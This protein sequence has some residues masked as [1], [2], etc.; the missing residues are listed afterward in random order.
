MPEAHRSGTRV[1][2]DISATLSFLNYPDLAPE[3]CR[4]LVVNAQECGIRFHR[5]LGL[6]TR[7]QFHGLRT[8]RNVIARVVN[9]IPLHP[10]QKAWFIQLTLDESGNVWG[11]EKPPDDWQ[12]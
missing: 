12:I 7:V 10:Y 2:C 1:S 5:P 4:V 9:C 6:G 8:D 11:I 3:A